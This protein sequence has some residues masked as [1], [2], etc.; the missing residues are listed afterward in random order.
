MFADTLVVLRY[1]TVLDH[2]RHVPDFG[3]TPVRVSVPQCDAQPGA[4]VETLD[5]RDTTRIA[6]TVF[7]PGGTDV[8]ATDHA[9]LNDDPTTYAVSGEPDRWGSGV[10]PLDHVVVY[11][12][13][14][15]G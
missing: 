13:M 1:P 9:S 6:W 15:V 3:A 2:G 4:T 8:R 10:G 11:L 7:A 14:W 12:E 5:H